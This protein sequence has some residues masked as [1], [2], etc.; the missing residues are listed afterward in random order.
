MRAPL[1]IP[2]MGSD[3]HNDFSDAFRSGS[4]LLHF[5][6]LSAQI[7]DAQ[8]AKGFPLL[9]TRHYAGLM[10][11]GNPADPLFR[12][13]W[14]DAREDLVVPGFLA[15]PVGDTEAMKAEGILQKYQ[16]RVLVM[17]TGGCAIHCRH[18]FRRNFPYQDLH[19]Q[20]FAE[21]LRHFLP[22]HPEV[23]EVILSGGDPLLLEDEALSRIFQVIEANPQIQRVRIHTRFPIVLPSRFTPKLL[24]ILAN[25]GPQ[26]ILVVH[27][28]HAQELDLK[29]AGVFAALRAQN[30][31]LLN[32]SVLL[33]GVNDS[34]IVLAELSRKL[35]DQGVLPYYLHQLD[36]AQGAAHFEVSEERGKALMQELLA[37]LPGYLV[38]RY[39]REIQGEPGKSPIL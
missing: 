37:M 15:D 34:A 9:V 8:G 6:G 1:Q 18:C 13:V 23:D 36:R 26:V 10:Q 28:N 35:F 38:P 4:A 11:Q 33:A 5:L 14:P 12:Q 27:C 31:H 16:S 22:E 29:S 39:V 2:A 32:Q 20:G 24:Q 25:I 19:T 30:V 17:P 3:W 21:R 7:P